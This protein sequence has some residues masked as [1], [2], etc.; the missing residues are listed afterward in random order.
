MTGIPVDLLPLQVSLR[1]VRVV[2][3]H[4]PMRDPL[5]MALAEMRL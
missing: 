2:K 1:T 3:V 5:V 4:L